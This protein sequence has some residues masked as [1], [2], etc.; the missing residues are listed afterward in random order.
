MRSVRSGEDSHVELVTFVAERRRSVG[1]EDS[2]VALSPS[3]ERNLMFWMIL[4]N[5]VS[6]RMTRLNSKKFEKEGRWQ[7]VG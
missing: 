4:E 3:F 6:R 5:I 7:L 2:T 1:T